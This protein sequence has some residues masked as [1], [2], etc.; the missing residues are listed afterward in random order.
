ME[1][2]QEQGEMF[3]EIAE[4]ASE[5]PITKRREK[6]KKTSVMSDMRSFSRYTAAIQKERK[7]LELTKI[8][9]DIKDSD[10]ANN[11]NWQNLK[12][13]NIKP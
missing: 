3:P 10:P 7:V 2:K 4:T 1:K 5:D 9:Q 11:P 13:F 8:K 6:H 12:D